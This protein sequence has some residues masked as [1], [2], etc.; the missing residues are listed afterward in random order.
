M[1]T[2]KQLKTAE[3]ISEIMKQINELVDKVDWTS[4]YKGKIINSVYGLFA[5]H[6]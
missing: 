1:K 4:E 6:S 5:C 2:I 3:S